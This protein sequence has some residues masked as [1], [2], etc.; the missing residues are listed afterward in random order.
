MISNRD[1]E[2]EKMA[3]GHICS[4]SATGL[5]QTAK[6]WGSYSH[7]PH[8]SLSIKKFTAKVLAFTMA[9]TCKN[10]ER[11]PNKKWLSPLLLDAKPPQHWMKALLHPVGLDPFYITQT[12]LSYLQKKIKGKMGEVRGGEEGRRVKPAC[13]YFFY[14]F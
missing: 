7:C 11:L 2:K 1:K 3:F 10:V 5:G 8:Y 12:A 14:V 4:T 6:C 13:Y 9:W